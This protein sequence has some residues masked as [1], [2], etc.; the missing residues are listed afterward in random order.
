M[1]LHWGQEARL[2]AAEFATFSVRPQLVQANSMWLVAELIEVD[3][4]PQTTNDKG[5]LTN[6]RES[7]GP[8]SL[9][10]RHLQ[11]VIFS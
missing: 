5:P 7:H 9:V 1:A 2:P 8:L 3:M 10:I 11:F 4:N 6:D